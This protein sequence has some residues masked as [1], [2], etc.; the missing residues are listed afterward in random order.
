MLEQVGETHREKFILSEYFFLKV[1]SNFSV[2]ECVSAIE[3]QPRRK[4]SHGSRV[5]STEGELC[6]EKAVTR[7]RLHLFDFLSPP[8][9]FQREHCLQKNEDAR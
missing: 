8:S 9:C 6:K 1:K 5:T 7:I 4:V 3:R 2:N